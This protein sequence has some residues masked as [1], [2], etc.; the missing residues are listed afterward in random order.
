MMYMERKNLLVKWL[1]NAVNE[2]VIRDSI[3][4]SSS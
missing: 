4:V 2:A 3:E 1:D